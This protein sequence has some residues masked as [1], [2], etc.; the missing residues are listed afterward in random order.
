MGNYIL[1][2]YFAGRAIV[3]LLDNDEMLWWDIFL[4]I[5]NVILANI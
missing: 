4:V 2:L 1:A 5:F 3:H